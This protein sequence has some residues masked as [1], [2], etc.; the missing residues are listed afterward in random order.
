MSTI[1]KGVPLVICLGQVKGNFFAA[2]DLN[3]NCLA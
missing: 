3:D 2:D 1:E